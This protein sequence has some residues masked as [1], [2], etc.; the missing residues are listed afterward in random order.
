MVTGF[1]TCV[2]VGNILGVQVAQALE[3]ALD[4]QWQWLFVIL[5]I[6]FALIALFQAVF[7]VPVPEKVGIVI[8]E[9]VIEEYLEDH[10]DRVLTNDPTESVDGG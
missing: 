9:T 4:N 8:E 2:C 10:L 5:A 1:C 6:L 3:R 7:L